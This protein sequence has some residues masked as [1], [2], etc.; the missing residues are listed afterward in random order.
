M[1]G[2]ES[3]QDKIAPAGLADVA[4]IWDYS[5]NAISK[6]E[7]KNA[8]SQFHTY[9][10]KNAIAVGCRAIGLSTVRGEH[11]RFCISY[12]LLNV[13]QPAKSR[14]LLIPRFYAFFHLH[15][16]TVWC[17]LHELY[18]NKHHWFLNFRLKSPWS[19]YQ[20]HVNIYRGGREEYIT[21]LNKSIFGLIHIIEYSI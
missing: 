6:C 12:S 16:V 19:R 10:R 3:Q 17:Q 4:K 15:V 14:D 13:M 18:I 7:A 5:R 8:P 20:V 21:L 11:T 1:R 2:Y 9:Y